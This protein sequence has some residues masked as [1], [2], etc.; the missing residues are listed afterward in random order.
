MFVAQT[1][2]YVVTRV[3]VRQSPP[4]H[5]LTIIFD[6]IQLP[7]P[8][9]WCN[10]VSSGRAPLGAI[11]SMHMTRSQVLFCRNTHVNKDFPHLESWRPPTSK[12]FLD[13]I[14]GTLSDII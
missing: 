8:A 10:G 2:I 9:S 1:T 4:P 5:Q 12:H 13:V 7:F 11:V 6:C 14:Q 3:N